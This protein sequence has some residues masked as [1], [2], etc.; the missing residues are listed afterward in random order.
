MFQSSTLSINK[1]NKN[2]VMKG[3]LNNLL[4]QLNSLI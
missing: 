1:A 2:T 3:M 4:Y